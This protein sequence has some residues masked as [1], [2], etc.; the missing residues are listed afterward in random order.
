MIE[1]GGVHHSQFI[2]PSSFFPSFSSFF[3]ITGIYCKHAKPQWSHWSCLFEM[4]YVKSFLILYCISQQVHRVIK[5]EWHLLYSIQYD[6]CRGLCNTE[7]VTD[8]LPHWW[9]HNPRH[10]CTVGHYYTVQVSVATVYSTR[11]WRMPRRN[12]DTMTC[13]HKKACCKGHNEK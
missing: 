10:D 13:F 1:K 9:W 8:I 2:F 12:K 5:S 4:I 11:S 6:C 7:L 3:K